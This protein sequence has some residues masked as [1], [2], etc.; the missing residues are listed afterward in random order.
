M[1]TKCFYHIFCLL[2]LMPLYFCSCDS[3]EVLVQV[4]EE[5]EIQNDAS[6]SLYRSS[7]EA[8]NLALDAYADFFGAS[9]RSAIEVGRIKCVTAKPNS[10]TGATDTLYYVVTFADDKG[11]ALISANRNT[12]A[13]LAVTDQGTLD[14]SVGSDNPAVKMINDMATTLAASGSGS[15]ILNPID[16]LTQN[17]QYREEVIDTLEYVNIPKMVDMALH[18]GSPFSDYCYGYYP[19]TYVGSYVTGCVPLATL[20]IMSYAK[21]PTSFTMTYDGSDSI[22]ALDW[23]EMIWAGS[24]LGQS[25]EILP[26]LDDDL[27]PNEMS[28]NDMIAHLVREIGYRGNCRLVYDDVNNSYGVGCIDD[29]IAYVLDRFQVAHGALESF[30]GQRPSLEDECILLMVGGVEDYS[31]GHAF[32]M[33]GWRKLQTQEIENIYEV[34][35]GLMFLLSTTYGSVVTKEYYHLNWGWGGDC[36]GYFSNLLF[37]PNQAYSYDYS[38]SGLVTYPTYGYDV[39]CIKV[40]PNR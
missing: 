27:Q 34:R 11:C 30:S 12:E 25:L 14:S 36:D 23:D 28:A 17:Y 24:R 38:T 13:V 5:E 37:N 1:K 40:Y 33:D 4:P 3:D 16:T 15:N 35:L 21:K 10:R 29:S 39:K 26:G 8:M 9:S 22:V 2:L 7:Q 6:A 32:I 31:S 19:S 20:Q 18:Q